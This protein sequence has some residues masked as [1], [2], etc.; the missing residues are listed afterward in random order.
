MDYDD[1]FCGI[2]YIDGIKAKDVSTPLS[3]MID[4]YETCLVINAN[5]NG[6]EVVETLFQR[7]KIDLIGLLEHIM[8]A[9]Y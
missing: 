6:D 9:L 1:K 7:Y 5:A 4:Y 8:M 3:F 2:D